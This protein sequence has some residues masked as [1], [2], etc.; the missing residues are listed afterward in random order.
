LHAF[1]NMQTI[2]L[3]FM[4]FPRLVLDERRIKQDGTFPLAVR[5]TYNRQ[6]A[7]FPAGISIGKQFWDEANSTLRKAHPNFKRLNADIYHFY[8]KIQKSIETLLDEQR[9]TLKALKE[10]LCVQ[11]VIETEVPKPI[12]F[13]EYANNLLNN[14]YTNNKVGNAIVYQTAINRVIGFAGNK[15][16]SFEQINFRFLEDFKYK[17]IADGVKVNTISNYFRTLRAIFNKAIKEKLVSK[18]AYYFT[19][20]NF[21]PERTAKRAISKNEIT[22]FANY[23][24][25][26]YTQE[27]YAKSYFLFS[28]NLIGVSFTDLAYLRPSNIIGDR[29]EFKRR[30]TGKRY[31][32]KLTSP[33]L[34]ILSFVKTKNSDY[35]L[36]ILH[37][38][39]VEDSIA[40][41]K[42]IL[43]WIKTTNKYLKRISGSIHIGTLTTYGARHTWATLAK[44]LGYSNELIAE[45]LG[46]EYGNRTTAIY[47]DDFEQMVIDEANE[48]VISFLLS[49][50][51]TNS[52]I[53]V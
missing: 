26:P 45:A 11:P 31:S 14:L 49:S 29:L 42:L 37:N 18:D 38:E 8:H 53:V 30:K 9:F 32:I 41:K 3:N 52:Q 21:K 27:W 48:K 25:L 33:A 20:I 16:I 24:V 2:K 46:H 13:I 15:D 40:A 1:A 5:V 35:L 6:T 22:A 43:Q 12:T 36:P 17:L 28:F 7:T 47:L 19:D 34:E 50:S 44:R 51:A 39:I 4:V 23:E 10:K